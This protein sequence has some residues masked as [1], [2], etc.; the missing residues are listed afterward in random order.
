MIYPDIAQC[1]ALP[2]P[3]VVDTKVRLVALSLT[4]HSVEASVEYFTPLQLVLVVLPS[5]VLPALMSVLSGL[6]QPADAEALR[7][8]RGS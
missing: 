5:V 7:W 4:E 6:P 3:L 1:E 2:A 8:R